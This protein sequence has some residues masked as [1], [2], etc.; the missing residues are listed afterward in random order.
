[1]LKSQNVEATAHFV[2]F[3]HVQATRS[4][5]LTDTY[6]ATTLREMVLQAAVYHRLFSP[7]TR[8]AY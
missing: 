2:L 4:G 7:S 5:M 6:T 1:M 8:P 3:E